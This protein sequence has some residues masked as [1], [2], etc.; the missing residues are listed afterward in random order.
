MG[1]EIGTVVMIGIEVYFKAKAVSNLRSVEGDKPEG[2]GRRR[3]GD[4]GEVAKTATDGGRQI[5]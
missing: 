5:G 3:R 2:V 1:E 4:R